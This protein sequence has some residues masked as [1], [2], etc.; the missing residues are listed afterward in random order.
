MT[1]RPTIYQDSGGST[2]RCAAIPL[3]ILVVI[4][5]FATELLHYFRMEPH[6]HV[7]YFVHLVGAFALLVYLPY[8]KFAHVLYRTTAMVFAEHIGRKLPDPAVA[9]G[10]RRS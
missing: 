5:G 4:T 10:S 3:L 6:R 9:R 2:T 8:S 7:M 1:K